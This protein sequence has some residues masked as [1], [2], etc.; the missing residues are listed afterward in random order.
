[1]ASAMAIPMTMIQPT[2]ADAFRSFGVPQ[3]YIRY[4]N[5]KAS[6]KPHWYCE[7]SDSEQHAH[8]EKV[9]REQEA[10][11]NAERRAAEQRRRQ[12]EREAREGLSRSVS[13]EQRLIHSKGMS[14]RDA[15]RY[16]NGGN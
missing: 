12:K 2:S 8:D 7:M 15:Y 10:R 5:C 6:G 4:H 11:R 14:H 16:C 3:S 1:M 9:R 13:C